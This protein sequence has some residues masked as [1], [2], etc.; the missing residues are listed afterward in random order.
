MSITLD[1]P[2]QRSISVQTVNILKEGQNPNDINWQKDGHLGIE[3]YE[4]FDAW[5]GRLPLDEYRKYW[6]HDGIQSN[7]SRFDELVKLLRLIPK[8][9]IYPNFPTADLTLYKPEQEA[10]NA[11]IYFKAPKLGHYRDN[12]SKE[13]AMRLLNEALIHERILRNP[14]PNLGSYL[15]CV[16]EEGRIVRLAFKKYSTSLYDVVQHGT[17]GE[18]TSQQRIECMD[19]VEAAA[20]HL[21]SL[22]LAHND[23]SPSNIMLNNPRQ[24]IL[25]DFDSAA[26]LGSPLTKGGWVT[27]WKGPLVG[28]GLQFKESSAECDK[29]AIQEI[30]EYL[31]GQ[32]GLRGDI[33]ERRGSIEGSKGVL[34]K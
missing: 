30:R 4:G 21:H 34:R 29:L 8:D 25:I 24:A 33:E 31:M 19:Q 11:A 10:D 15:G 6:P 12:G 1:I 18:F 27:G 5:Y 2:K 17:P 3:A 20:A 26:P 32:D 14:H 23:I 9:K 16:T 7:L 28:E 13:V 22:G